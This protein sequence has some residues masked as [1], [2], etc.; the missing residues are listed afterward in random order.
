MHAFEKYEEVTLKQDFVLDYFER[1]IFGGN[2]K[3]FSV[4][5]SQRSVTIPPQHKSLKDFQSLTKLCSKP[6]ELTKSLSR[7][8]NCKNLVGQRVKK[9]RAIHQ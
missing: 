1:H 4:S 3:V 5:C 7:L 6:Q 2:H 8:C 9:V